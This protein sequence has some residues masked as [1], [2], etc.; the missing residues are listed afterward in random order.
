MHKTE[1]EKREH[2]LES[3]ILAAEDMDQALIAAATLRTDT[4]QDE[5]W[6]RSLEAAMAVCYA[7]P[8]TT[9][10]WRL[11]ARYA[12]KTSPWQDLHRALLALRKKLYAHSDVASGRSARIVVDA[13][14]NP[15]AYGSNWLAFDLANLHAVQ[16]LC[17]DRR[18][19]FL[20]EAI[21]IHIQLESGDDA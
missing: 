16:A 3:L 18:Q 6:R 12:P 9:G 4:S 1:R 21:E 14:G 20:D 13:N 2:L 10:A 11:G 17:H 15:I 19:R 8:F 7:R 5:A